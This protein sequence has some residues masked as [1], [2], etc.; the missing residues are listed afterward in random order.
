M[1]RAVRFTKADV[2]RAIAAGVAAGLPVTSYRI[3]PN[4]AIEVLLAGTKKAHDNDEW[5]DLA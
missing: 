2:R 5:A 3:E 1:S 4:G